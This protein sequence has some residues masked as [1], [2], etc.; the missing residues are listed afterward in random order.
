MA[1]NAYGSEFESLTT[2]RTMVNG[3]ETIEILT[4]LPNTIM[5]VLSGANSSPEQNKYIELVSMSLAGVKINPE[6][7]CDKVDYRPNLSDQVPDSI[8]KYINYPSTKQTVWNH[9]GCVIFDL[10]DPNPFAYLLK[11]GNKIKF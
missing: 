9:D 6:V 8:E 3:I 1:L 11:I 5:C 10:F 7:M 4:Y 2:T